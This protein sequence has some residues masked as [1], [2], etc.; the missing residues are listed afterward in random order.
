M[1]FFRRSVL[2]CSF[3]GGEQ[4]TLHAFP[5][6]PP[7]LSL[8]HSRQETLDILIIHHAQNAVL[9]PL[10]PTDQSRQ[11]QGRVIL[12]VRIIT[13]P[14]LPV[15]TLHHLVLTPHQGVTHRTVTPPPLGINLPLLTTLHIHRTATPEEIQRPIPHPQLMDEMK[16]LVQD[17]K[18][19]NG[20]L[21]LFPSLKRIFIKNILQSP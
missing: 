19:K 5:L 16:P 15:D 10:F 12:N 3:F 7:P 13:V 20:I 1:L 17:S 11:R 8:S 14:P 21:R 18:N 2:T 4:W 9:L 6:H